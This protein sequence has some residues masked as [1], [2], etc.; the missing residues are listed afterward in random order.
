MIKSLSVEDSQLKEESLVP[1]NKAI[2]AVTTK[3]DFDS[4]IQG[5]WEDFRHLNQAGRFFRNRRCSRFFVALI[6]LGKSKK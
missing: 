3:F 6:L 2:N 1:V 4:L 5:T